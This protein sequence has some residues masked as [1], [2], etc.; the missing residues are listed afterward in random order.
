VPSIA[1][2]KQLEEHT[3]NE[4]QVALWNGTAGQAWVDRQESLDRL[5][6]PFE[7]LLADVAA[8]RNSRH[9]LDVGCG[10]GAT[11]LAIARRLGA[12]AAATGVDISEPMI[13]LARERAAREGLNAR[14]LS[15]D[16]QTHAFAPHTFDLIVSRFGVMFFEDPQA[17]FS[18]L[19]R[20]AQDDAQLKL[21]AWRSAAD[22]PFMTAAERAAA[23]Y[24]PAM[25]ARKPDEPGQFGFADANRVRSILERAGW[26]SVT[27]EPLDVACTLPASELDAYVTKLG[28]LGRVLGGADE[29]TRAQVLETVRAAFA[30][31]VHGKEVRFNAACW[32]I[33]AKA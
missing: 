28:P 11:T 17:A 27:I 33:S 24:L 30:P 13:A 4:D 1:T 5:F 10:T 26:T 8:E 31:Y 6:A 32:L 9:V 23:P 29:R 7:R 20:A 12:E 14:F 16:A 25:P 3:M 19:H 2:A 15:A 22:N 21:I 18:N